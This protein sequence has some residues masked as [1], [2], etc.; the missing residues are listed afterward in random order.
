MEETTRDIRHAL[1][2]AMADRG[3]IWTSLHDDAAGRAVQPFVARLVQDVARAEEGRAQA[4]AAAEA[5]NRA[6]EM[7]QAD[8][9]A[10]LEA[11][12]S[13]ERECRTPPPFDDPD[14]LLLAQRR[15]F[16]VLRA[17]HPGAEFLAVLGAARAAALGQSTEAYAALLHAVAAWEGKE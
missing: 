9:A 4:R 14:L 16:S 7:A 6:A 17:D 8:S 10:L 2:E 12:R 5:A 3:A 11:I 15:L 1:A 13:Y